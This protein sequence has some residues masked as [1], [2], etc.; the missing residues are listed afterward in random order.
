MR[1]QVM[2]LHLDVVELFLKCCAAHALDYAQENTSSRSSCATHGHAQGL[3]DQV[4]VWRASW[5]THH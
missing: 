1:A 4:L 2:K 3:R 5:S